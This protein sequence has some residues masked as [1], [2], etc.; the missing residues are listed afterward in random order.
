[1]AI[2]HGT[3]VADTVKT[4]DFTGR[5][6]TVGVLNRST[7]DTVFVTV[8]STS[9][10]PDDP[11]HDSGTINGYTVPPGSRRTITNWVTGPTRVKLKSEN[12]VKYEIEGDRDRHGP[13]L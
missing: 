13:S 1:M 11:D 10:T 12:A 6:N 2:I 4:E 5:F 7:S 9:D 3:T 8:G